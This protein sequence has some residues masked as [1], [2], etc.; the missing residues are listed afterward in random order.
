MNTFLALFTYFAYVFVVAAYARKVAKMVKMPLHLRWELYPV[1]TEEGRPYGG[2]YLEEKEWWQEPRRKRWL[3]G[4]WYLLKDYFL[5]EEYYKQ[6]RGYWAF[7]LAWHLGFISIILFHVLCFFSA[8]FGVLGIEISALS[9]NPL[10]VF[11]YYVS[12]LVGGFSFVVGSVGAVGV[13]V[14]RRVDADLRAYSF[15][16]AYFNYLFT[17]V[18][19]LSAFYAW[20]YVDPHFEEY[21]SFWEGLI[22]LSPVGVAPAAAFHIVVFNLFLIYLPFTRS[23]H[24]I[25]KFLAYFGIRWD[26]EPNLP[27]GRLESKIKEQLQWRVSWSAP[28]VQSGKSWEEVVA[29]LPESKG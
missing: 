28:H 29:E 12:L 11:L 2:S 22:T 13:M 20:V 4:V 9:A 8:L 27:G 19:F 25:L 24:Y 3:R 15:P 17:L 23:T 26:D 7:L 18:V 21:R 10:G 16:Q 1:V 14:A 6:K 5:M